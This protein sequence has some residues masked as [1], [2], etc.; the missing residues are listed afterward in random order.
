MTPT[1]DV[2]TFDESRETTATKKK[3]KT[4]YIQLTIDLIVLFIDVP[5]NT[6]MFKTITKVG[7]CSAIPVKLSNTLAWLLNTGSSRLSPIISQS[8]D[9]GAV[10]SKL[11]AASATDVTAT[12]EGGAPAADPIMVLPGGGSLVTFFSIDGDSICLCLVAFSFFWFRTCVFNR[13]AVGFCCDDV[14]YGACVAVFGSVWLTIA[15]AVWQERSG[16]D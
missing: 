16:C 10:T 11:V 12:A 6:R 14:T 7:K 9:D 1:C 5:L 15:E 4:R 13:M 8:G 3:K 2:T